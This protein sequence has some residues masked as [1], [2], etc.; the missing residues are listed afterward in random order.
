MSLKRAIKNTTIAFLAFLLAA[1]LGQL[2]ILLASW[3]GNPNN[4]WT[5]PLPFIFNKPVSA[6]IGWEIIYG[7]IALSFFAAVFILS[8]GEKE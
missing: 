8:L 3:Y 6:L 7:L 4:T 2:D 5:M 1:M